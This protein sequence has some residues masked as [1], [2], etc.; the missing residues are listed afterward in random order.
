MAEDEYE[1]DNN[2]EIEYK[3]A[4]PRRMS[5]LKFATKV[6]PIPKHSSFFIFSHTN[7]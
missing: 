2:E 6:T 5:E 3:G 7:K 4:R 1:T